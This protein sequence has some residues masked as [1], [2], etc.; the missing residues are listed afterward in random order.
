MNNATSVIYVWIIHSMNVFTQI[1][2][3]CSFDIPISLMSSILCSQ[4]KHKTVQHVQK[5]LQFRHHNEEELAQAHSFFVTL[6]F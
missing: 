3:K 2:S 1:I 5:L 6:H 4:L